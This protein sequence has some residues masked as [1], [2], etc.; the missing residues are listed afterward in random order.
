M[1]P[2]PI[3]RRFMKARRGPAPDVGQ[4]PFD[5]DSQV[6]VSGDKD[7]NVTWSSN[8]DPTAGVDPKDMTPEQVKEH[9]EWLNKQTKVT[10]TGNNTSTLLMLF[11]SLLSLFWLFTGTQRR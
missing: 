7:G 5:K 10:T 9:K 4:L 11:L 3:P 2:G 1:A 8:E 6:T